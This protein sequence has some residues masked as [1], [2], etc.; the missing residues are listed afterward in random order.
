[1]SVIAVAGYASLDYAM[2]LGEFHGADATTIVTGRAEV[3]PRVGGI[4]HVT[5]AIANSFPEGE[6]A[7]IAWVGTDAEGTLWRDRVAS[8]GVNVDGVSVTGS[9]SP[10]SHLLYPAGG[11]TMCLFDPADCHPQ[12][13]PES[14]VAVLN[15]ADWLVLTVSPEAAT[16]QL[17]AALPEHTRLAWIV[18]H[19]VSSISPEL[20]RALLLRADLITL[21]EGERGFVG[22]DR[23]PVKPGALII[24]TRGSRGAR[25][26]VAGAAAGAAVDS[27]GLAF[28]GEVAAYPVSDVDTTGAGDTFAGAVVAR[29]AAAPV[30][31]HDS[32]AVSAVLD[33][34]A[35]ATAELLRGRSQ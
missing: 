13:L 24:E 25:F 4:A 22:I 26:T 35:R 30:D 15:R 10:S 17:L 31:V 34:A 6:T 20:R 9:R 29:L 2:Q 11:G 33:H 28:A 12:V 8:A 3:W 19:D 16:H 7:A 23:D 1:M 21:S 14:Q 32:D 27:A 18:K 5:A